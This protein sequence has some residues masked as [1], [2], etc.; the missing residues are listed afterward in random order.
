MMEPVIRVDGKGACAVSGTPV[1][2]LP[3]AAWNGG[4][5]LAT[6]AFAVPAFTPGAFLLFL[7]TTYATLL[8]GHS[9]GMHRMMIHRAF[10]CP[11]PIERFLITVGVLVGVA[12][13]FGI[14]R[15]HDVRDWAQRQPRCHDFFAHTRP[16]LPDLLWHLAYRFRFEHPPAVT[17]ED[18]FAAD[19]WHRF[20]ERTWRLH[21]VPL[22]VVF[23]ALGGWPWVV[24]GVCA[25]V[26]VS[27]AGHWTITW[28]CHNPGAGR[29]QVRGASV[30]ASNL[31]GMGLLTYRECWHN[32]HH[33]FPES[34]RIGLD[35]GQTDPGWWLI[36]GLER[37]GLAHDVGRPRPFREREDLVEAPPHG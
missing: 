21:Q 25:R 3:K 12:G 28:Y 9:V 5:L 19:P 24:W 14:I 11:K 34:A 8:V 27:A 35:A 30:Q 7:G 22:A 10:R 15:V 26:I 29:W 37:L 17:I 16:L 32:N 4:M 23:Y 2:D 36:A 20:L 18:R 1:L 31:G 6:L 33:A 13:P